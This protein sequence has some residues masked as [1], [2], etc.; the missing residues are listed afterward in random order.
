[1]TDAW[2]EYQGPGPKEDSGE[3]QDVTPIS[4]ALDVLETM[5]VFKDTIC[6][7]NLLFSF[8]CCP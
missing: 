2:D 7:H 4:L 8:E 1:M 3:E 6:T 5:D